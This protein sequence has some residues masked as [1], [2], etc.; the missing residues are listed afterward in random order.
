MTVGINATASLQGT[1]NGLGGFNYTI[2][3]NDPGSTTIGTFWFSWIPGFSYMTVS[4]TSIGSPSGWSSFIVPESGGYS[5]EWAA[6]SSASYIQPNGSSS[7]FTFSSTETPA[8]FAAN[9][10]LATG[11]PTTTSFVYSG[12]AL[13][14]TSEQIVATVGSVGP[15]EAATA[16]MTP[17]QNTPGIFHYTISLTDTGTSPIHTFWFAWDD[18]PD[19]DFMSQLPTNIGSPAGW[20]NIVTTHLY[21]GGTGYGIEWI[22][23]S[24]ATDISPSA[25]NSSFSFDSTETP[26]QMAATQQ[27]NDPAFGTTFQTTSSFVY[28]GTAEVTAGGNL[29][30]QVACFRAGTRVRTPSGDI[31]VENLRAGDHVITAAGVSRPLRWTGQRRVRCDLREHPELAWPVRVAKDALETG[32][33]YADLYISPDH[34]LFLDGVLVPVKYLINGTSI[35]RVPAEVV[36]WHH[37]ELDSHDVVLAEGAPAES[38]LDT[39]DRA[40]F[41]ATAA[42]VPFPH[43]LLGAQPRDRS[44][45]IREADSD[46]QLVVAGPV[47]ASIHHRLAKRG[48]WLTASSRRR[49]AA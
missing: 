14:S 4:P 29:I 40:K 27:F 46:L 38:Y 30:V 17:Q 21:T 6:N 35:A 31:A 44:R 9:T 13:A 16:T 5:I 23:G 47:V 26:A 2:T 7:A 42:P 36:V 11:V 10:T 32:I 45:F 33:P 48:D 18:V 22:S 3:L 20:T 12:A 24:S 41:D 34:A 8:Q 43:S 15:A 49:N 37:L 39:G 28:S 1:S 19:Q 25:V